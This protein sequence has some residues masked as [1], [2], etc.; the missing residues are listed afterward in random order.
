MAFQKKV[1]DAPQQLE[2]IAGSAAILVTKASEVFN[3]AITDAKTK[4]DTFIQDF[5]TVEQNVIN[6]QVELDS[7]ESKLQLAKDDASASLKIHIKDNKKAALDEF[8]KE[9]KVTIVDNDELEVLKTKAG[10]SEQDLQA[11]VGKMRLEEKKNYEESLK[12]NDALKEAAHKQQVAE[13]TASKTV[14]EAQ[15]NFYQSQID[16]LNKQIDAQRQASVDIA[17]AVG[18]V[19]V[20]NQIPNK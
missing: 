14:L 12:Q 20:T 2:T 7:I 5:K 16:S 15:I 3:V 17:K 8:S 19:S 11:L 4:L 18:N 10:K 6:K 9:L 13:L 1:V